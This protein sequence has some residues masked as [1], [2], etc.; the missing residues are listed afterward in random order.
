MPNDNHSSHAEISTTRLEAFSDAVMAIVITIGVLAIRIPDEATFASL[1]AMLP[2]LLV[3]AIGFQMIGTYWNNHHHLLH[4]TKHVT[5]GI[6]WA[7][8]ALLFCLSLIPVAADW[9]GKNYQSHV[10]TAFYAFVLLICAIAY[11]VLEVQAVQH[12]DKRETLMSEFR[13][14]PKGLV[15]LGL[16]ILAIAA[17]F[18]SPFIADALIVLVSLIWFIPDRRIEKYI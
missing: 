11:T 1:R 12:S 7:N 10:A 16:Y 6:M 3:Y 9:L 13:K 4:I 15:S 8:L 2:M 17:A 5:A 18:F 14:R